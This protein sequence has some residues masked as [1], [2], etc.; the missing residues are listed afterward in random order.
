[1]LLE[2]L[3]NAETAHLLQSLHKCLEL[4]D[5]Y[6]I[7]SRQRLGDDPRDYDGKFKPLGDDYADVSGV[8]PDIPPPSGPSEIQSQKNA[9]HPWSIYP[10]PPPPHWHWK[11]KGIVSADGTTR[12]GDDEFEYEK[13]EIPGEHLGWSYAIDVKGVFQVYDDSKGE[14]LLSVFFAIRTL[15]PRNSGPVEESK[16]K[17]TDITPPKT[18]AFDIP[19]IREYF[20]DLEYVLGVISDG[21]TKSFA[22]RRLKYLA[23][24]FTMY[25]LLNEFQ[26]LA[27]MKVIF[28]FHF[29]ELQILA[30]SSF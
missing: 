7:K 10:R 16:E 17:K 4:R 18:P 2:V 9:F 29:G 28:V 27:D 20:V 21:P 23:S 11:D 3:I 26:E 6:M 8:R 24:K 22:F 15:T 12:S 13:C 30:H 5:K 25:S 1:M 19:D 14:F